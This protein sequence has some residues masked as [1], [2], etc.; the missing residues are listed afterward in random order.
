MSVPGEFELWWWRIINLSVTYRDSFL[1]TPGDG[2]SRA[3][4]TARESRRV[5]VAF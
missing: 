4:S 3:F 2:V 5:H 1:R